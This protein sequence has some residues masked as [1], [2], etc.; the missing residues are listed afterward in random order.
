MV[1]CTLPLARVYLDPK[2][3]QVSQNVEHSQCICINN[4]KGMMEN[5]IPEQPNFARD[6]DRPCKPSLVNFQEE[7]YPQPREQA[8]GWG[9]S[10]FKLIHSG[11]TG[12]AA[13]TVWWS[14]LANLIWWADAEIGIGGML[15]T[16]ILP[17]CGMSNYQY[18]SVTS[19]R[20]CRFRGFRMLRRT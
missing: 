6:L 9:L 3:L 7:T 13:G 11:E 14:G 17:F 16:Q 18:R 19:N 4:A 15:A 5:Q 8:Q 12:R 1:V 10:F 20:D 2:L